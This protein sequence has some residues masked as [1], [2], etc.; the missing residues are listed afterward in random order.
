MSHYAICLKV[1]LECC[2]G[3]KRKHFSLTGECGPRDL[4]FR[5]SGGLNS[6][7]EEGGV[8][9]HPP[10]LPPTTPPLRVLRLKGKEGFVCQAFS[11]L[12]R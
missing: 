2:G 10:P 11:L 1:C 9:G 3:H 12:V 6:G 4:S 8:G 7:G 5:T